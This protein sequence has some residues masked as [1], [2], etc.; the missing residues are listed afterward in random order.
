[1]GRHGAGVVGDLVVHSI[2]GA[3]A[4]DADGLDLLCR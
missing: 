4:G 1:M 2:G 3:R